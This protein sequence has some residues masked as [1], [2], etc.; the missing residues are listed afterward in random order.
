MRTVRLRRSSTAWLLAAFV[1]GGCGGHGSDEKQITVAAYGPFPAQTIP[2]TEG[3]PAQCRSEANAFS[4]AAVSFLAPFPSDADNYVVI[5]RVQF[6]EFK[7]HLCDVAILRGAL[8][9]RSTAKQREAIIVGL[10]F[11]DDETGRELTKTR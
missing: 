4:R 1:L 8:M 6:F 5:A 10:P 7:A 3:S 11:L 2:V 9:R